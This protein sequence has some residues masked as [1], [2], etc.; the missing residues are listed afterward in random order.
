MKNVVPYPSALAL[1]LLCI[2][3]AQTPAQTGA[4]SAQAVV[5]VD[6]RLSFTG[7]VDADF[8]SQFGTLDEVRHVSGL[9]VDVITHVIFSR[10]LYGVVRTTMR[11]GNVPRQGDGKTWAPL[12]FDGVQVNWKPGKKTVFMAGDIIAGTGYF[13]Y[14]R[15][16][17][18][19][20]V[21]GEHS[22]RGAG[23]RHGSLLL[24]AGVATDSA[25]EN[26]DWSVFAKWTRPMDDQMTWTPSFRYTAGIQGANPFELGVSFSGSFEETFDL[27]AHVG[28]NYWN[29]DTDPGSLVLL[30][31]RYSYEPYFFAA[32]FFYS[33]KG[34]VT[35]PNAPRY[36]AT[37]QPLDDLLLQFEP[38]LTLSKTF[39]TGVSFE[40]RN[41]SLNMGD[42]ESIWLIPTL[43]IDPGGSAQWW[44][45]GGIEKPLAAG[46]AGD[47]RFAAGSEISFSF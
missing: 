29:Q 4:P 5:P 9:E 21:V 12:E 24:H 42:D 32:T 47:P 10:T 38:G 33:D 14:T 22:V 40:Y 20:A 23:V 36:T 30:E 34:E 27:H 13:Q 19:A 45:W 7:T 39:A 43:Y 28:M 44:I 2:A 18:T 8:S 46:G 3:V 16:K 26:G 37:W 17:R 11:D 25:G 41:R 15:Y 1:A 35:S 6:R 31:P